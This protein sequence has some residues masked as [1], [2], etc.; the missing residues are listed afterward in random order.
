MVKTQPWNHSPL[1]KGST[2]KITSW[3]RREKRLPLL[4]MGP[5]TD[6]H[7]I[8]AKFTLGPNEFTR[9][10]SEE[11]QVYESDHKAVTLASVHPPWRTS[12]PRVPRGCSFP[13]SFS[14]Y[15]LLPLNSI[16][17]NCVQMPEKS[18]HPDTQLRN[19]WHTSWWWCCVQ[20]ST[21][22]LMNPV[23]VWLRGQH[24]ETISFTIIPWCVF[25]HEC[26]QCFLCS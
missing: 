20:G 9:S 23:A 24:L 21:A 15:I 7:M 5:T 26:L 2:V 22:N 1:V 16:G 14:A 18:I 12:S 11:L 13:F 8:P 6:A 10:L 17:P 3:G 4:P 25:A 19:Q